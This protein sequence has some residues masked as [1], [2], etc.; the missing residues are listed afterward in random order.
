[1]PARLLVRPPQELG[2]RLR[3]APQ[4]P[5]RVLHLC[6]NSLGRDRRQPVLPAGICRPHPA[7]PPAA[8]RRIGR[9]G[10]R[11][12][13]RERGRLFRQQEEKGRV[14]TGGG[15]A[16]R[17]ARLRVPLARS[18]AGTRGIWAQRPLVGRVL[19]GQRVQLEIA[20]DQLKYRGGGERHRSCRSKNGMV[21]T[22]ERVQE[23]QHRGKHGHVVC[24]VLRA[25]WV[26]HGP[27]VGAQGGRGVGDAAGERHC[28]RLCPP[29]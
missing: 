7:A 22:Q 3:P 19:K 23:A 10:I 2:Q 5:M 16:L 24:L 26:S 14:D 1:M 25:P 28:G 8:V 12:P 4:P 17:P 11:P 20:P 21:V 18:A 13:C 6:K 27:E 9:R 29:T 15:G